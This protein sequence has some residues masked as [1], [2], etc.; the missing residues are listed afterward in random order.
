VE[1]MTLH[2]IDMQFLL[3]AMLQQKPI[4][5]LEGTKAQV[6]MFEALSAEAQEQSLV[7]VLD[8]ILEPVTNSEESVALLESWF[9]SWKRGDVKAFTDSFVSMEGEQTEYDQMLFGKRDEE[10]AKKIVSVLENQ[11]G[12]YFLVVGAGHFVVDK[13]IRYHLEQSGYDVVPF[14]E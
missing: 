1:E 6:D 9:D 3:T 8:S 7:E 4:Y 13:N 5:E 2:G 11:A 12:T 14:Y 10:M